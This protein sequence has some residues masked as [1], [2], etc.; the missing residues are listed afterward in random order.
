MTPDI[1]IEVPADPDITITVEGLPGRKGDPGDPGDPGPANELSVGTVTTGAVGS[2]AA[3]TI[4][5]TPPT[6]VLDLTIPQGDPGPAGVGVPAG[7]ATGQV[8]T[9]TS[10]ADFATGWAA[11]GGGG[12]VEVVRPWW[13]PTTTN[14]ILSNFFSADRPYLGSRTTGDF[15]A[16]PQWV[17]WAFTAPAGTYALEIEHVKTTNAADITIAVDGVTLAT[18]VPG[19]ANPAENLSTTTVANVVLGTTGQHTIRFTAASRNPLS[20]GWFLVWRGW[21]IYWTGA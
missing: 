15:A 14:S 11:G 17:Q 12:V 9:K 16:P 7:G 4:T 6:Q 21:R 20:T 19:Y 3:A 2:P 18:V 10:A 5:G 8:L 1:V 13:S